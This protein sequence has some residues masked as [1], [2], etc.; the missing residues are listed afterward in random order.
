MWRH[1][2]SLVGVL[3]DGA[4]I[5]YIAGNST[6]YRALVSVERVYAEMLSESGFNHVECVPIRQC[7]SRKELIEFDVR[8]RWR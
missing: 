1:F 6:F 3:S 7:N 5:H 8:A 4:G 2:Q